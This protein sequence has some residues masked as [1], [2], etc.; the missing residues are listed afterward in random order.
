MA[1][2][3]KVRL[4]HEPHVDLPEGTLTVRD[5]E[6]ALGALLGGEWAGWHRKQMLPDVAVFARFSDSPSGRKVLS[7]LLL[8]AEG[9]AIRGETLRKVPIARMENSH[10]LTRD[11]WQGDLGAALK[12]LPPLR[13][14]AGM[15]PEDFSQL[16]A[17]HYEAWATAVPSPAA[18]IAAEWG[19]K[20]ATVHSW[21]REARL[22]GYLPP[23]RQ[24]RQ[25]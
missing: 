24:G 6:D 11:Y 5:V 2:D 10:N 25:G 14:E 17:K 12:D 8:L 20:P 1:E 3:P 22:R 13:R 4:D 23:A 9:D 7:G 19:V 18:A 15:S 21:I 16:V